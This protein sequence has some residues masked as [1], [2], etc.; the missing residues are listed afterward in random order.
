L[1]TWSD[2]RR[3]VPYPGG[4]IVAA[5]A[6]KRRSHGEPRLKQWVNASQL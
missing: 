6:G 4:L 2:A 1:I 5:E 3:K